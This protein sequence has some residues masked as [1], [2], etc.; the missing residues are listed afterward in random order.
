[1][2]SGDVPGTPDF[3]FKDRRVAIFVDGCFWHGCPTCY[4]RPQSKQEYW[5]G[6]LTRNI[7][8]DRRVDNELHKLGIITVRIWEHQ[9]ADDLASVVGRV[10]ATTLGNIG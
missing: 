10:K 4:R 7:E 8:R 1:M 9:I 5:D 6:K 3:Y 2:H